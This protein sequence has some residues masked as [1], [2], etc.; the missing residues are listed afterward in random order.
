[1]KILINIIILTA[2]LI[3][4]ILGASV[5]FRQT[6]LNFVGLPDLAYVILDIYVCIASIFL[7]VISLRNRNIIF[8]CFFTAFSVFYLCLWLAPAVILELNLRLAIFTIFDF[9]GL[10]LFASYIVA[11]NKR[12]KL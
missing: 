7:I 3:L 5:L 6:D 1:M 11:F 10:A 9:L 8:S 2:G 12:A 4:F